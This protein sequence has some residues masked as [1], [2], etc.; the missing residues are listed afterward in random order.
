[1]INFSNVLADATSDVNFYSEK[2]N[3]GSSFMPFIGFM[4]FFAALILL[5]IGI[6]NIVDS[7]KQFNL[8]YD[9]RDAKDFTDEKY[10][11]ERKRG[12]VFIVIA[13]VLLIASLIILPLF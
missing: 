13:I 1:M 3:E 2:A 10:V 11:K 5:I 8:F 6:T 9:Q 4:L 7:K 12:I